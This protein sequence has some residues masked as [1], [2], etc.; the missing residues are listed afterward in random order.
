M[1]DKMNARIL[2][3]DDQGS[4]RRV[5]TVLIESCLGL[6]V[7][8]EAENGRQAIEKAREL[9]PDLIVLDLSMPIMDGLAAARAI[10]E[11]TPGV[12]VLIYTLYVT[13]EL[14]SEAKKA[15]VRLVVDKAGTRE[16]LLTA[17]TTLLANSGLRVAGQSDRQHAVSL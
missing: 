3:A 12:P 11:A 16:K 6:E 13:P 8:G 14:A 17:M 10:A 4:T 7:C 9:R 15:G 2:I 1:S 5:L